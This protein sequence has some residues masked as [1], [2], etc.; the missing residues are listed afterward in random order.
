M[1]SSPLVSA[2]IVN[3]N[4]GGFLQKCLTAL[5]AQ[6]EVNLEIIVVDNASTD[7]S[8]TQLRDF[9]G[10]LTIT[11]EMNLG[12]ARAQ[13]Q[14]L[15]WASGRYLMPLN[16]DVSLAPGCI[17]AMVVAMESN[18]RLGS[19]SPLLLQMSYDGKPSGRLDNAGLL[20]PQN[21]FPVRRGYDEPIRPAYEHPCLV[22]GAMGAVAL[23]RREMLAD[24]AYEGQYFDE[25]FFTWYED[26]DLEWRARLRGWDCLYT[27]LAIAFHVGDPHG[28]GKSRLGAE[29]S[30]SNRWKMLAGNECV[31][32][33]F[34]NSPDLAREE[35]K[36]IRYVVRSRML[37]EYFRALGSF[38]KTIRSTLKKRRFVRGRVIRKCL[39]QYPIR[40][41]SLEG[42]KN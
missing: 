1:L 5:M 36:L 12:F 26:V 2:V 22:F 19:V 6:Q 8:M 42:E 14:G 4:A 18:P 13:N 21:R 15:R 39:P 35:S 40:L 30:M 7:G 25:A 10:C 3:Y 28:H 24:I 32:C 23:Y 41:A 31:H 38:L 17:S 9:P 27:P 33:L 16:F 37:P 11:N 34:R 20:L 29:V